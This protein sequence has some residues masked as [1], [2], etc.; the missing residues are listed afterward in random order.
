M[1]TFLLL[2]VLF[3]IVTGGSRSGSQTP[4]RQSWGDSL[5]EQAQ[6]RFDHSNPIANHIRD[7][8]DNGNKVG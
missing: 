3:L 2:L 1:T 6:N 4:R 7:G 8:W 5:N